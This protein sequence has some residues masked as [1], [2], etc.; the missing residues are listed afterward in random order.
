MNRFVLAALAPP[1][2]SVGLSSLLASADT[3]ASS[4]D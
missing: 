2:L 3:G 1:A 4:S